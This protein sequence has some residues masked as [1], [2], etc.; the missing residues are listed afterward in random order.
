MQF[1]SWFTFP[2]TLSL[3]FAVVAC[4]SKTEK[5]Q[6]A[7]TAA[8]ADAK[9]GDAKAEGG[10]DPADQLVVAHDDTV[11][12]GPVPPDADLVFF[13]VDGGL[14]PLGCFSKA[15]AKVATGNQCLDMVADGAEV[16]VGS[17]DTST[18]KKVTGRAEPLCL[19]GSGKKVALAAE[20]LS[21]EANYRFAAWPP[22]GFRTVELVSDDTLD[23]NNLV[24]SDEQQQ[25]LQAAIKASG[26][27][28]S[29]E[30]AAHQI[31]S[32]DIDGNDNKETV[33]SAHIPHPKQPERYLWSGMFLAP[34][35]D[36]SKLALLSRSKSKEDVLEVRGTIDI[37]GDGRRELW[38]RLVFEEGG[39][40]RLFVVDANNKAKPL[41]SWTCGA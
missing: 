39:G 17:G 20:G 36:L 1:R 12:K 6:D 37:D 19:A 32:V 23:P 22:A 38:M 29:G 21:T 16:R 35:G 7:K 31:A 15:T 8:K 5:K 24:L 13:V 11:E 10:S 30:V 9:N 4:G 40:D 18:L 25:A 27:R 3:V 26:A 2:A 14:L 34:D 41:G 33:F 28:A